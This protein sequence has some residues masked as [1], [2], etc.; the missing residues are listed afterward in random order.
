MV[1]TAELS[2]NS[3][4]GFEGIKAT[5]CLASMEAK[6]NT[7]PG[8]P[9]CL[10]QNGIRSRNTGKERDAETGLDYFGARYY[11][12]AMGRFTSSDPAGFTGK[13]LVNP[14]KWNKYSY[15]INNPLVMIDPN[16][17]AEYY[18]FLPEAS[19]NA[20]WT[21]VRDQM[22][23]RGID[24]MTIYTEKHATDNNYFSALRTKAANVI[25]VGHVIRNSEG[26]PA[27]VYLWGNIKEGD[28]DKVGRVAI[29]TQIGKEGILK[30]LGEVK[31]RGAY[32][33]GCPSIGLDAQYK[34]EY[35]V[36][37]T[38]EGSIGY[39]Y[40]DMGAAEFAQNLA[41]GQTIEAAIKAAQDGMD[42]M[43]SALSNSVKDP[44]NYP[45]AC[46][47]VGSNRTCLEGKNMPKKKE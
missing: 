37:T 1:T 11:S 9:V 45:Q 42:I 18:V 38:A 4:Q 10:W 26:S 32:I 24:H 27:S 44:G 33:F 28:K 34:T 7:A 31:I 2:E 15:V 23:K 20:G 17:E 13:H 8:M 41:R 12:G 46:M 19:L 5:L 36:G 35:F 6:S 25:Y 14:Q 39:N 47:S 22:N 21:N 3:H 40:I 29:G 43:F 30:E 16:G